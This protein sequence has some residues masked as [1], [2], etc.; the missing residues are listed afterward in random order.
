MQHHPN[1]AMK[2]TTIAAQVYQKERDA[3]EA[4]QQQ[5]QT[6]NTYAEVELVLTHAEKVS[7][8]NARVLEALEYI[9]DWDGDQGV[10]LQPCPTPENVGEAAMQLLTLQAVLLEGQPIP[11][12]A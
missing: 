5:E 11:E 6:P 12:P 10:E 9:V 1:E 4:A 7:I 3:Q 2:G 8:V